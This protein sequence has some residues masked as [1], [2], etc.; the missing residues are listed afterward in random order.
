MMDREILEHLEGDDGPKVEEMPSWRLGISWQC[1]RGENEWEVG[2]K[3]GVDADADAD[4]DERGKVKRQVHRGDHAPRPSPVSSAS[5]PLHVK[6][7]EA[8][9]EAQGISFGERLLDPRMPLLRQKQKP[10]PTPKPARR[11]DCWTR[12]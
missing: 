1:S 5:A 4:D 3:D 6:P 7:D 2:G 9:R 11:S 10:E 12:S 8:C